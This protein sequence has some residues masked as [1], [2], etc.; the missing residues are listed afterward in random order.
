MY[1][2]QPFTD[3]V[4]IH[5]TNT[6]FIKPCT[7]IN[8]DILISRHLPG[9][10]DRVLDYIS[11]PQFDNMFV[12]LP[13]YALNDKLID[14][15]LALTGK[16]KYK[17]T[18]LTRKGIIKYSACLEVAEEIGLSI[19]YSEINNIKSH[20][21][22][23]NGKKSSHTFCTIIPKSMSGYKY[24]SELIKIQKL[25]DNFS[26]RIFCWVF[27]DDPSQVIERKR[28]PSLDTAGEKAVLIVKV[29][30]LRFVLNKWSEGNVVNKTNGLLYY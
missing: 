8:T 30:F 27:I 7:G 15:Q 23:Y 11:D 5:N 25:K 16:I 29:P 2:M 22:V 3:N 10:P 14:W 1:S 21:F 13:T 6:D 12:I 17:P 4:F 26:D 20:S 18:H 19:S 24:D 9:G 28:M